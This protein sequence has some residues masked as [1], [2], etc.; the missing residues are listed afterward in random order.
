MRKFKAK[1]KGTQEWFEGMGCVFETS[2]NEWV[3]FKEGV[4]WCDASEWSCGDWKII[5]I[6]TLIIE[7]GGNK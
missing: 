3:I 5:D 2:M 4:Y 7:Q 6:E 1:I